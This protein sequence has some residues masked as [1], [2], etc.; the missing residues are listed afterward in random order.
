MGYRAMNGFLAALPRSPRRL[1]G[2]AVL[3][4]LLGAAVV[5]VRPHLSAWYHLRAARSALKQYHNWEAIR[6]LRICLNTWPED[7]D[8]LFLAARI[9]RRAGNYIEAEIALN[10]YQARRGCD[11]AAA[12]EVILLRAESGDVDRATGPCKEWIEQNHPDGPFIFEAVARGYLHAYRLPEARRTIQRWRQAQPDNP[13]TFFVEGEVHDC[14]VAASEAISC[15]KQV[16][17]TDPRHDEARLKLTAALLEHRDFADAEPHLEYL[18]QHQPDNLQVL[19]RLAACRAFLGQQDEAIRLLDG[20]LARQPHF[21]PALAERGK[22]ALACEEYAAAENWLREAVARD[23]IDQPTRYSL[24]QCLRR[25]GQEAEVQKQE[26]QLHRLEDDLRRIG[27]IAK[28][29]MSRNPHN[30]ALHSELG[31][32]FLRNGLLEQGS[33]WLNRALQLDAR[34][35]PAHQALA[36]YYQRIGDAQQAE[37]HRRL[38]EADLTPQAMSRPV[39]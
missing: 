13:Q 33:R 4:S 20:I 3:L 9:A 1:L 7:A 38:A 36:D 30:A 5:L 16:L 6:H 15:Y 26:E 39:R 14:E 18:R 27:E 24:V 32:I 25:S 10:K 31:V 8:A 23:P 37:Q 2:A 29:G 35:R 12:L 34:Y 17:Q 11:D 22:I 28:R 19:A 21:A